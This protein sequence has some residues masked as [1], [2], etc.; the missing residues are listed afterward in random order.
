MEQ[1]RIEA[2]TACNIKIYAREVGVQDRG[3]FLDTG[4][5]LPF[6]MKNGEIGDLAEAH[7]T[8]GCCQECH[9]GNGSSLWQG[10]TKSV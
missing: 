7:H 2:E 10:A 3:W 9:T 6:G 1:F 8:L 5:R 4:V